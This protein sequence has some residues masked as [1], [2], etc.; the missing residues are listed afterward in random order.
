[1]QTPC[2]WAIGL[3]PISLRQEK[4]CVQLTSACKSKYHKSGDYTWCN[5]LLS[6]SLAWLRLSDVDPGSR[7]MI[8]W[9]RISSGCTE[10]GSQT[11]CH[12]RWNCLEHGEV[13]SV[14]RWMVFHITEWLSVL[15]FNSN[16]SHASCLASQVFTR[17]VVSSP[18]TSGSLGSRPG[19]SAS[20]LGFQSLRDSVGFI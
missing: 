11:T 14:E 17:Q 16:S 3:I 7:R 19:R 6:S 20:R 15:V 5:F 8:Y 4:D 2:S 9:C 10:Q 13:T 18:V 1:M 12:P